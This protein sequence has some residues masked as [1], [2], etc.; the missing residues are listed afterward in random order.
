MNV[1]HEDNHETIQSFNEFEFAKKPLWF[2][3]PSYYLP[4]FGAP[5]LIAT[6]IDFQNQP[7]ITNINL[8]LINLEMERLQLFN[9]LE[10]LCHID[11]RPFN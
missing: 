10:Q 6:S 11:Q 9:R 3:T 4:K 8:V 5:T 7:S 1:H 2:A